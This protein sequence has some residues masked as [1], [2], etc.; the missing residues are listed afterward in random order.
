MY[1][2]LAKSLVFIPERLATKQVLSSQETRIN[3]KNQQHGLK[4]PIVSTHSQETTH[5]AM[6]P[7]RPES[8]QEDEDERLRSLNSTPVPSELNF[9][10]FD[11][12][13]LP[14]PTA[15]FVKTLLPPILS[16]KK[17]ASN[18]KRSKDGSVNRK[19]GVTY[20]YDVC[21][22]Y[23][24]PKSGR[25]PELENRIVIF[26]FNNPILFEAEE[27]FRSLYDANVWMTLK[28]LERNENEEAEAILAGDILAGAT[29]RKEG[30]RSSLL[31]V[32][33]LAVLAG[34][35][36]AKITVDTDRAFC[37]NGLRYGLEE[38]KNEMKEVNT[39]DFISFIS[40]GTCGV[41]R[42]N[43]ECVMRLLTIIF[44]NDVVFHR[45]IN[46]GKESAQRQDLDRGET[47]SNSSIWKLIHRHF[48]DDDF[49]IADFFV[50]SDIYRDA[51][52]NLPN[53]KTCKSKWA[54][55]ADLRRWY[56]EVHAEMVKH[57]ANCDKSGT[58]GFTLEGSFDVNS[59][60]Y[61]NFVHNFAHG[62]KLV[63]YLAALAMLRGTDSFDWFSRQMP[64]DVQGVDGLEESGTLDQSKEH[65][66]SSKKSRAGSTSRGMPETIN[67][68]DDDDDDRESAIDRLA[69]ALQP[70]G[71][72][73]SPA[74]K[75]LISAKAALVNEKVLEAR[76]KSRVKEDTDRIKTI[77]TQV[78]KAKLAVD[79]IMDGLDKLG[80]IRETSRF[81]PR[82][83]EKFNSLELTFENMISSVDES[84]KEVASRKRTR[85][86]DA[87]AR[88]STTDA[89]SDSD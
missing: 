52:N 9:T 82:V 33:Y 74:R 89:H 14:S 3:H 26:F 37:Y 81:T 36:E 18:P 29:V 78:K 59:E 43:P 88:K 8:Y 20:L 32:F 87:V 53:I 41:R 76:R 75:Q 58:H 15:L 19:T 34:D 6:S 51:N 24:L 54:E 1:V 27:A 80:T 72:V 12:D 85:D 67:I 4:R 31:N 86:Y 63:C 28:D 73:E 23:N 60:Q 79:S 25:R 84:M 55:P 62:Q 69:A 21:T 40:A 56:K 64:D 38:V 48:I 71:G 22:K 16:S 61:Q 66:S 77:E 13:D 68:D 45:F 2:D 47:G 39:A 42:R 35:V 10:T 49:P 50:D 17:F 65:G 7:P 83:Q 5:K 30:F 46:E 11:I 44:L 57:K 70:R